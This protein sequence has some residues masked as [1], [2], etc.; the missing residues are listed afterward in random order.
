VHGGITFVKCLVCA[1]DER[2]RRRN[3]VRITPVGEGKLAELD[4]AVDDA[5]LTLLAPLAAAERT[6]LRR[7]VVTLLG[8]SIGAPE[9]TPSCPFPS[10]A[11]TTRT[12]PGT[13]AGQGQPDI[14]EV[15]PAHR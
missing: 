7:L 9:R 12:P 5:Q 11:R 1:P 14:A 3:T 4:S 10:P 8:D 6:G 15:L 2:D 13:D